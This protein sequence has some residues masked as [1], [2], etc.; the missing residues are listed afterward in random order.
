MKMQI[1]EMFYLLTIITIIH[2]LGH[3]LAAKY[4]GFN[5]EE[6]SIGSGPEIFGQKIRDTKIVLNLALPFGG[7]ISV[8]FEVSKFKQMDDRRLVGIIFTS[9]AGPF[10]NIVTAFALFHYSPSFALLSIF[11]G[12]GNLLPFDKTDGAIALGAIKE[13]IKRKKS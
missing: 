3:F 7:H 6:F 13:Y 5:V 9:L 1:L 10:I 12:L 8:D 4:F 2:E 11:S